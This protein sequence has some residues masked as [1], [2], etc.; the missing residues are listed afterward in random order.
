ML[1]ALG[2]AITFGLMGVINMAHGELMMIGAY[3]TYE[4]QM[5]FGHTPDNPVNHYYLAALPISI[6]GCGRCWPDH[7]RISCEAFVQPPA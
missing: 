7:G 6:S 5:L 3:T 1:I 4:V 2:L